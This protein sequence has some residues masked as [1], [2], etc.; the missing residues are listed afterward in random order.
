[1]TICE[2]AELQ[3]EFFPQASKTFRR[4]SK[5]A[6]SG[7]LML[8]SYAFES[9]PPTTYLNRVTYPIILCN[10]PHAVQEIGVVLRL[11]FLKAGLYHGR[12]RGRTQPA[13]Q[14]QLPNET[15]QN[16]TKI[17]ME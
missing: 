2:A 4:S 10:S 3:H 6:V 1:M 16:A 14:G 9:F 17:D 5:T 15:H 7:L 12:T 8:R 13:L 11:C